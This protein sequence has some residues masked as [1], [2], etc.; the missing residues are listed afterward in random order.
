[1]TPEQCRAGRG[2]LE[3][4]QTDLAKAAAVSLSTI[5]DFELR[6]R[7]PIANN[8]KAIEA[9]LRAQGVEFSSDGGAQMVTFT[10]P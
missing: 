10:K 5:R 4:S 3:W 6:H 8:L 7:I 2:F 9:A 1:M